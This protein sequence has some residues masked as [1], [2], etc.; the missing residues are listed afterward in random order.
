MSFF[1]SQCSC[2]RREDLLWQDFS[3]SLCFT[4]SPCLSVSLS[5]SL[6]LFPLLLSFCQNVLILYARELDWKKRTQFNICLSIS[7]V[8]HNIMNIKR[9]D[10]DISSYCRPGRTE[11]KKEAKI[12]HSLVHIHCISHQEHE[13]KRPGQII[14]NTPY[15]ACQ[16]DLGWKTY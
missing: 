5:V 7:T 10:L 12:W 16:E 14:L 8:S 9:K 1:P 13:E 15:T 4:H 11:G 2:W 6:T 3:L